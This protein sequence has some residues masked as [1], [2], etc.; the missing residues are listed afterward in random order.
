[1][2]V[3]CSACSRHVKAMPCPFCGGAT[4]TATRPEPPG[5]R[6]LSRAQL[7]GA[8]AL[9]VA[10]S[11]CSS[12]DDPTPEPGSSSSSSGSAQPVY[13]APVPNPDAGDEDAGDDSG[14]SSSGG[15]QPAY[16][17]PADAGTL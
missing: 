7:L 2:L 12:D 3:L 15:V 16:G 5:M 10:A 13:G 9:V 11:A 6:K 14:L 8:A 4:A 1:M 17:A